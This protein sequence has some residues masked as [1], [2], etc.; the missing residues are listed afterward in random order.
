MTLR[1]AA[2]LVD[3]D[4]V[5]W[6]GDDEIPGGAEGVGEL[7]RAGARVAFFTNNSFSAVDR[8][9][10][11]LARMGI[12]VEPGDVLTSSQ[13][14][15]QLVARGDAVLAFGGPGLFESLGACGAEILD[16]GS[17]VDPG[18]PP[19]AGI[20]AGAG[21]DLG[22]LLA[23]LAQG[24]PTSVAC[25]VMGIDP[26]LDYRRLALAAAAVRNGARFVATNTDATF[27]TPHGV[28][29]GAGAGVAAVAVASGVSPVVAGKPHE[30]AARLARSRLGEVAIVIGD[31]PDT[32]GAFAERLGARFALVLSGVT[33]AG[34]GALDP[35]PAIE[36]A[37]LRELAARLVDDA[38]PRRRR[39][40]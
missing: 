11:K 14:A 1:G 25:V 30:P 37:D 24:P 33:P 27:P 32:D 13:A 19:D 23:R 38:A 21:A 18:P 6:R 16:P 22:P 28:V 40:A 12:D 31:R 15:A 20:D 5:I 36:A 3:L 17:L 4:G 10:A 26:A 34:H 2:V 7:R 39:G 35:P 29:P 8:Q 9:V